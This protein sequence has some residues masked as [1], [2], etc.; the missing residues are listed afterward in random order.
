MPPPGKGG[1]LAGLLSMSREDI[2]KYGV[3]SNGGGCTRIANNWVGNARRND[4][5]RHGTMDCRI[6]DGDPEGNV[7]RATEKQIV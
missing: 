3:T 2:M 4:I 7:Q 1:I 6:N 5:C